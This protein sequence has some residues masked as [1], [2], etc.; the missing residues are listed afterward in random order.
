MTVK[1]N[2]ITCGSLKT[3]TRTIYGLLGQLLLFG[4]ERKRA[5]ALLVGAGLPSSAYD[6]PDFPISLHQ[7]LIACN[8]LLGGLPE[9]ISPITLAFAMREWLGLDALGVVGG[10]IRHAKN[11][12][13][14]IE[15]PLKWPQLTWGHSRMLLSTT[16]T[17]ASIEY[18]LE[19]LSMD[20]ASDKELERLTHYFVSL[21][22]A[23]AVQ[24]LAELSDGANLPTQI[25]LPFPRPH[26]WTPGL[27][28]QEVTFDAPV[29]K[30]SFPKKWLDRNLP[31]F[32]SLI[33]K[34]YSQ[35]ADKQSLLLAEDITVSERVCRWLWAHN[36]PLSRTEVAKL[37][38][39]S[40][41][42]LTRRLQEENT[43]F[44]KLLADVQDQ[45]GKN[46][47]QRSSLSVADIAFRLGYANPAAFSRAF[48][49][50]NG[51]SPRDWRVTNSN[52]TQDHASNHG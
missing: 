13:Q 35:M 47:L 28:P 27:V 39:M 42:S 1:P 31:K 33:F 10:A 34:T 19:D 23:A 15:L 3:G 29:A 43:T 50:F 30:L 12:K 17:Q 22:I 32:S 9:N 2:I 40:E 6:H 14:A 37:M 18:T 24:V 25:D 20:C 16:G 51:V 11:Y 8:A 4:Y 7:E 5:V 52:G 48:T 46:M 49:R 36:S 41:R 45:R 26:D 44:S 21:D 38:A